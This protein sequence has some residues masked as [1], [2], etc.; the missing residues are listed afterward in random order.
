MASCRRRQVASPPMRRLSPVRSDPAFGLFLAAVLLIPWRWPSPLGSI[1]ERAGAADVLVAAAFAVW[2]VSRG[3]RRARPRLQPAHVA[4]AV[5]LL[6]AVV[7]TV[8]AADPGH[9]L[10]YLLVIFEL[11]ALALMAEDFAGSEP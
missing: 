10:S 4:L 9:S 6:C 2:V 3:R 11:A 7:S 5:F 8:A 1:N